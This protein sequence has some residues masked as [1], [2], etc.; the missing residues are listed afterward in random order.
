M[1][2][3]FR[4]VCS[5]VLVLVA[6]AVSS[7]A[8]EITISAEKLAELEARLA[9][10]EARLADQEQETKEVKVLA[11][12]TSSVAAGE[13]GEGSIFGNAL[14]YDILADS[15]W[16]NLRW[17]QEEQW[18]GIVEGVTEERV[19]ELLGSPPRSLKSLKPRIDMV[20]WY[21][22]S[23][24][25]RSTAMRGKISFKDGKVVYVEKPNFQA[26]QQQLQAR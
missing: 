25:D 5:A 26:V 16:R 13:G 12:A 10:L 23:L 20:Y 8:E 3:P 24:R 11:T 19:V 7:A 9:A 6:T 14:T 17:T 18:E 2:I 22:T 21:E 1:P 15:A 4:N